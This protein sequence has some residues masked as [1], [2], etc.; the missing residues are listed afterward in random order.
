[1]TRMTLEVPDE[2]AERIRPLASWLPAL[3]ELSLVGCR[4]PAAA[5]AAE[6]VEFLAGEPSSAELIEY[7][8]SE[9]AQERLQHLLRLNKE[10]CLGEDEER[11]LDE[12]QQIEHIVVMLKA[13]AAERLQAGQ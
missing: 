13:R 12:L 9:R 4:T 5:T 1:M 8:A 2:L 11:E 6:V 7:Q 3:L 10:D